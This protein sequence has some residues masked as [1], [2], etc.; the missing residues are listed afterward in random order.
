MRMFYDSPQRFVRIR[1]NT[2]KD[3]MVL[4]S[5]PLGISGLLTE[6]NASYLRIKRL[7]FERSSSGSLKW[8]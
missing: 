7:G 5:L 1:W 8:A 3:W 4:S 6:K 2:R